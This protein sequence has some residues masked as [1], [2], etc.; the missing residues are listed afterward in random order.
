M[1][2]EGPWH[3]FKGNVMTCMLWGLPVSLPVCVPFSS[4]FSSVTIFRLSRYAAFSLTVY[5]S[6]QMSAPVKVSEC[7]MKVIWLSRIE[8]S[9]VCRLPFNRACVSSSINAPQRVSRF[10]P[11]TL[12]GKTCFNT[13]QK[14]LQRGF[15]L[16]TIHCAVKWAIV[17]WKQSMYN[18]HLWEQT[19]CA[20][21]P[22]EWCLTTSFPPKI[23]LCGPNGKMWLRMCHA[24]FW[25]F[26]QASLASLV[27]RNSLLWAQKM[28]RDREAE[29][30]KVTGS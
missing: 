8:T 14:L 25:V 10:G 23:V 9:G 5:F 29:G 7:L 18:I 24:F 13:N 12:G 22:P 11:V 16:I 19:H 1:A 15:N 6:H 30:T 4:A 26:F 17:N 21:S 27:Q 20:R 3:E 2:A 28:S